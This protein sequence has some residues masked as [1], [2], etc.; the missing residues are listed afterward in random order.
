[1]KQLNVLV[2]CEESQTV[3]KAFR[4]LGH[5][6]FSC[7]IQECSGGHQE[8]H[9][10]GDCLAVI[11]NRGG[12]IETGESHFI[13]GQWDLIIAHPPCTYLSNAGRGALIKKDKYCDLDR[14]KKAMEAKEFFMKLL[15]ADCMHVA[16]ENPVSIKLLNMPQHSQ[17]IQPY[18]FGDPISKTTRL[19]LRGLPPLLPTQICEK[20]ETSTSLDS[21]YY[22][23]PKGVSR[24]KHRSK[25]FPGIAKAMAEQ[26]SSYLI[27]K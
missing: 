6:A 4:E 16:V 22:N 11:E 3:C 19:W 17:T 13:N 1:M 5:N 25:T 26:W 15:N 9:F 18:Y 10:L 27:N 20:Y 23:P 2:A 12:T 7:D 21:W 24:R 8:W 14:Y